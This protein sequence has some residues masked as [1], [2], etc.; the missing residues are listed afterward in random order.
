[1][2]IV[3]TGPFRSTGLRWFL[4][5][6]GAGLTVICKATFALHP[7]ESPLAR[8]QDD[9]N[10]GDTYWDDDPRR[11]LSLA[12]DLVPYKARADVI[13]VGHTFAPNQAPARSWV[14]RL[15][16]GPIHKA[17][18]VYSERAF[19]VDGNLREGSPVAK[20]RLRYERAAGGPDSSNPVGMRFDVQ[21]S[22]GMIA[23]PNLQP[24]GAFLSRRGDTFLPIGFGPIAPG[25][26]ER[27]NRLHGHATSFGGPGWNMAPLPEG[28]EAAYFNAAPYDQ[29]LDALHADERIVLECLHPQHSRLVTR[30]PGVEP[31]AVLERA[32]QPPAAFP[33]VCDTLWIDTDRAVCNLVWRGTLSLRHPGEHGRILISRAVQ[34]RPPSAGIQAS[35]VDSAIATTIAPLAVSPKTTLPFARQARE[36]ESLLPARASMND[37][38]L[39]FGQPEGAPPAAAVRHVVPSDAS[40]DS[41]MFLFGAP[42]PAASPAPLPAPPPPPVVASLALEPPAPPMA[43]A[44]PAIPAVPARAVEPPLVVVPPSDIVGPAVAKSAWASTDAEPPAKRESIGERMAQE[45]ARAESKALLDQKSSGEP[46]KLGPL[47]GG[48]A[49][50]AEAPA[51]GAARVAD[52]KAAKRGWKA[53]SPKAGSAP[54]TDVA[55][56]GAL[57]ASNAAVSPVEAP[58]ARAAAVE[59]RPLPPPRE[60]IELLWLDVSCMPRVRRQPAWKDLLAQLKPKPLDDEPGTDAPAEKKQEARDRREMAVLLARGE[61]VDARGLESAMVHAVNEDGVFVPPLVL[62]AGELTLPFDEVEALKA[63]IAAVTP[64]IG[65]DVKLQAAVETAQKLLQT[66]WLNGGA[67]EIAENLTA[68]IT[69]AFT[70]ANRA[71]P[72][73][74]LE[75]HTERMLLHQRAYQKRTVLGKTCVRGVL[76]MPG[77]REGLAVYLPEEAAKELP[78]IL[79]V[80]IRAVGT[81]RRRLEEDENNGLSVTT[82]ALGR[83]VGRQ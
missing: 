38:A 75:H 10:E 15:L 82:A 8:E 40:A 65:G 31:A 66:P 26:P 36:D 39:P 28:V 76:A 5:S 2:E 17:I 49:V 4:S 44:V 71:V 51:A 16:I 6:G 29:Q 62:V 1:M 25:W 22:L 13:V 54:S 35:Q 74:Y 24:P 21:S 72:A 61:P 73:R 41:T 81:L 43:A 33:L 67:S 80:S 60:A 30:L 18:E 64:L 42:A 23:I 3:T 53:A 58:A 12:T 27:R 78:A 55:R 68:K 19:G 47:A 79:R 32:G 69:E 34:P 50:S 9:L 83:Q 46:E 48:K 59:P 20:V 77:G 11:S 57:A 52:E 45:L 70:Q 63:T 14:A 37:G 56:G 7:G